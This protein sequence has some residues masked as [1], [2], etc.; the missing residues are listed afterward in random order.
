MSLY[1]PV[2]S[3]VESRVSTHELFSS[4]H[5]QQQRIIGAWHQSVWTNLR[6]L[7]S[8]L[9]T[10]DFRPMTQHYIMPPRLV[11]KGVRSGKS[12]GIRACILPKEPYISTKEPYNV[13]N[14]P[15]FCRRSPVFCQ[16]SSRSYQ[17]SPA[18]YQMSPI[19]YQTS[20]TI[21]QKSPAIFQKI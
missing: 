3:D 17:K 4:R 18:I 11:A 8:S 9:P 1:H 12:Y 14:S 19:F 7:F 5:T 6:I 10:A 21:H 16:K 15:I 20:P 13:P 2:A